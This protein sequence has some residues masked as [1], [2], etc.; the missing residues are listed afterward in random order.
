MYQK[1]A[2][3]SRVVV[4]ILGWVGRARRCSRGIWHGRVLLLQVILCT[5]AFLRVLNNLRLVHT[6]H[7]LDHRISKG[8]W[9]HWVGINSL[10]YQHLRLLVW[11]HHTCSIGSRRD[12]SGRRGAEDTVRLI[13]FLILIFESCLS[14]SLLSGKGTSDASAKRLAHLICLILIR[15]SVLEKRK[16]AAAPAQATSQCLA[17]AYI[18]EEWG[19][20]A[21]QN[22][23][24]SNRSNFFI[25]GVAVQYLFYASSERSI[26]A[27][28]VT[29]VFVHG[30]VNRFKFVL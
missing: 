11:I 12:K 17:C 8:N 25:F 13:L 4:K 5:L 6:N 23:G 28:I 27:R 9:L 15:R 18:N 2:S 14:F 30:D 19:S 29:Q 24:Q 10:G 16:A 3:D 20:G 1:G 22:E 7:G 21:S 26:G